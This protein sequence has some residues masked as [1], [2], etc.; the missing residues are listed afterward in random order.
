MQL[1]ASPAIPRVEPKEKKILKEMMK[2]LMEIRSKTP[3]TIPITNPNQDLIRIPLV[4]S[5][6]KEIG[7]EELDEKS[8]FH[9]E[10]PPR[11]PRRGK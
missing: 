6:G 4:E 5:K 3:P 7:R 2:K 9:Q 8:S 10:P 11:A 1:K